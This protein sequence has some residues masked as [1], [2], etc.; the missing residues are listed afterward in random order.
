M[1]DRFGKTGFRIL[2]YI[3]ATLAIAGIAL[4]LL[5]TTPFVLLAAFFASKGS[6]E[7]A[8]WLDDHPRFG[9]AIDQWRTR[10]AIPARAK[11][12]ACGMMALSWGLLVVLGAS[13]LVLAL[14]GVFLCGTACY[15]LTRPSY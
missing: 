8:R 6:P 3:S 14:S 9:P 11:A 7:F 15:L 4:P 10:R 2:A 1:G 5:P 12:L 13:G